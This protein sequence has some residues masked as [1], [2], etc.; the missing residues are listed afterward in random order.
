[1]QLEGLFNTTRPFKRRKR[2]GRGLGSKRGQTCCRGQKGAGSR[3][4]WKSRARYEGGQLPLY[5]KIPVRGFSNVQFQKKY[6]V[7]NL[8]EIDLLFHDGEV[9]N[10]LTLR[11]KQF[12]K[13]STYGVKVLGDGELTKKVSIEAQSFSRTAIEKLQT[14]G[15]PFVVA[16]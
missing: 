15:V 13:G 1:M 8:A 6:D 16:Q 5:R 10:L 11:E 14:N 3:S 9:V 2:V 12:L 4:G 7:I